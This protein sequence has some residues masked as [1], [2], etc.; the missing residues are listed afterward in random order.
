MGRNLDHIIITDKERDPFIIL[1]P[2]ISFDVLRLDLGG[3]TSQSS[4]DVSY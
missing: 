4:F 3:I 2:A 1:G